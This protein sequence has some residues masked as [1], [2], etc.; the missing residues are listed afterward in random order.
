MTTS[1][2]GI[3]I[4]L[5]LVIVL[6]IMVKCNVLN[7]HNRD[8]IVLTKSTIEIS[9]ASRDIEFYTAGGS[10]PVVELVENGRTAKTYSVSNNEV[11]LKRDGNET[12]RVGIP[13]QFEYAKLKTVSGGITGSAA[14]ENAEIG[15][16]S[17]RVSIDSLSGE[18]LEIE[19]VSGS[20][21]INDAAAEELSINTVSGSIT[22]NAFTAEESDFNSVSGSIHA[23]T[24]LKA[25]E[26][27]TTTVSGSMDI[28]IVND[29]ESE[30]EIRIKTVSGS[31]S[32]FGI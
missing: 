24:T 18:D 29:P 11:R 10:I 4:S 23:S 8:T 12:V 9:T 19:S 3:V 13:A 7:Q 5:I 14:V 15:T 32:I 1:K 20:I 26:V 17:G 2:S 28:G 27:S 22:V 21:M 31:A 25:A 30:N 16:V 6:F